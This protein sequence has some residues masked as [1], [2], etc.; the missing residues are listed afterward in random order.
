MR[1]VIVAIN[2]TLDGYCDHTAGRVTYQL[3]EGYWPAVAK[4]KTGTEAEIR[5]AE[6]LERVDKFVVSKTLNEVEWEG[7][8]IIRENIVEKIQ[9]LKEEDGKDI[10]I[11]GPSL[12][13]YLTQ[14]NLIDEYNLVIQP[15]ILGEG[16]TLFK[17]LSNQINLELVRVTPLETGVIWTQYK[18]K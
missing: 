4:N 17:N 2:M 11:G 1:K 10:L 18:V 7:T 6:E 15:F 5:F 14:H 9:Q 12:I 3:M 13:A 8:Q 16:I